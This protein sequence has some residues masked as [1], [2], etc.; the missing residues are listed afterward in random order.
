MVRNHSITN[1][2]VLT[3]KL[4]TS[5]DDDNDDDNCDDDDNDDDN[6]DGDD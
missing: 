4:H 3:S 5:D 1:Y 2:F 6:C